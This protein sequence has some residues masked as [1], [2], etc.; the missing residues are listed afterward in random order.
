M[1]HAYDYGNQ[2]PKTTLSGGR[3]A[4]D[5]LWLLHYEKLTHQARLPPGRY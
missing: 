1:S 4:E 3:G 2:S 5:H